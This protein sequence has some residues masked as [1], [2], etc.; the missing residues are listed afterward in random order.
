M[1]KTDTVLVLMEFQQESKM[2][3][4]QGLTGTTAHNYNRT[5]GQE[6]AHA[7]QG[8]EALERISFFISFLLA[9]YNYTY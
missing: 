4:T 6:E 7:H 3:I 8:P 2:G 5:G 1:D 9:P